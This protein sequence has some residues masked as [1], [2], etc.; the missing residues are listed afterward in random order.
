MTVSAKL[1]N[2]VSNAKSILRCV[3]GVLRN[4]NI[5]VK[6]CIKCI[7]AIKLRQNK[8]FKRTFV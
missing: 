6:E 4:E 7:K 5:K 1:M 3:N 2:G 8:P